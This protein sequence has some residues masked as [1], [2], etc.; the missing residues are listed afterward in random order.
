M[1]RE[2]CHA[3]LNGYRFLLRWM[4]LSLVW[5]WLRSCS[6]FGSVGNGVKHFRFGINPNQARSPPPMAR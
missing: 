1:V 4:A 2:G 5:V 3:L 6:R